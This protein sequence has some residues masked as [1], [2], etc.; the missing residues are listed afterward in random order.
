[1]DLER[2]GDHIENIM[3]LV[4]SQI[5]NKV[6][7]SESAIQDLDRMFEL[8]SS[9]L[10]QALEAL[11]EDNESKAG[12]VLANERLINKMERDLR[13]KHIQRL[14]DNKCTGTAGIVYVDI[15]SNLER[16]GD[17]AVNIAQAVIG[18]I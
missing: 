18:D 15:V 2:I 12:A 13:K 10:H 1:M 5:H 4:D 14:N 16:I 7:F 3:E 8:T 17:H 6:K 9:T 11:Q